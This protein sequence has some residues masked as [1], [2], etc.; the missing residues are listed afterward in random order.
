MNLVFK[1][2]DA[3]S[4]LLVFRIEYF[5]H[6]QTY[7]FKGIWISDILNDTF[8]KEVER[9]KPV[10]L[11]QLKDGLNQ[12]E[13]LNKVG[14][15]IKEKLELLKKHKIGTIEFIQS[16]GEFIKPLNEITILPS[17]DTDLYDEFKVSLKEGK[18]DETDLF[19]YLVRFAEGK[20]NYTQYHEF[21]IG[22]LSYVVWNYFT[23]LNELYKYVLTLQENARFIDFKSL[24][25]EDEKVSVV[26]TRTGVKL[27]FNLSKINVAYLFRFFLKEQII[28]F[29]DKD[30]RNNELQMKSLVDT[31]FTYLNKSNERV[32]MKDFNREYSESKDYRNVQK[33]ISFIDS[34]VT[35]LELY[36]D[37]L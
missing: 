21:Q 23:A 25:V 30:E 22:R 12:E 33:Y 20:F 27:H 31:Y 10:L 19:A 6:L 17:L 16:Y 13:Y 4:K 1:T 29:D 5:H 9:F 24:K 14:N 15:R 7:L 28:V 32:P 34:F 2:E 37:S 36:R 11:N 3:L 26:S 8:L 18:T 35:R